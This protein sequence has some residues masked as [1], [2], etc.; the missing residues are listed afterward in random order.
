MRRRPPEP[1]TAAVP[2]S[3]APARTPAAGPAA[4]RA[5]RAT[6]TSSHFLF[7]TEAERLAESQIQSEAARTRGVINRN[8]GC[9]RK[10]NQ[11]EAAIRS[12]FRTG[13][14]GRTSSGRRAGVERGVS[15][16]TLSAGDIK[17]HPT[18]G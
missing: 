12:V 7:R 2:S 16:Q 1:P 3:P 15:L 6:R 8:D 11:I 9:P 10:S 13:R 17:G 14:A 18:L 4:K 5:A